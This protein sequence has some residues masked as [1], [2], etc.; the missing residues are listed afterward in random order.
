M[1]CFCTA[2]ARHVLGT[3]ALVAGS[4]A[5]GVLV[6]VGVCQRVGTQIFSSFFFCFFDLLV[7]VLSKCLFRT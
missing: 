2:M 6:T 7:Q 5:N 3:C 1:A 4:T